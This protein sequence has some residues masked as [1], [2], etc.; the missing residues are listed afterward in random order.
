[1]HDAIFIAAFLALIALNTLLALTLV[2]RRIK[3]WPTPGRGSWQHYTFWSLFR[4]GLGLTLLLGALSFRPELGQ[5]WLQ[6]AIGVPMMLAGFGFLVYA[7]FNLGLDNTH[8][9][10]AG[11][12]TDGL[13]RYS[14]NPQ[15][16]ASILGFA[17]LAI[18][19]NS[20]P[21]TLL[22]GLA[23]LVYIL[24]PFT[25]EPWLR[26]RYGA[27]FDDYARAT[28]RFIGLRSMQGRRVTPTTEPPPHSGRR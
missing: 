21:V 14:R 10:A 6:L 16:V 17:G 18:A 11:L 24:M 4:G 9:A 8:G 5:H 28:P 20:L 2:S 19:V 15:C 22:C 26:A 27:A 13:Y 7:F 23:V 1:M 12:V 25:E 3:L